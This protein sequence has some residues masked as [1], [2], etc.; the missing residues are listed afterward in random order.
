LP[1][2][3]SIEVHLGTYIKKYNNLEKIWDWAAKSGYL[4]VI[5]WLHENL[6]EGCTTHAMDVAAYKGH[7][8]IVKWLHE[9]RTEGCSSGAI[10]LAACNGHLDIIKFVHEKYPKAD[11]SEHAMN[12]AIRDGHFNVVKYIH[13]NKLFYIDNLAIMFAIECDHF[14]IFKWLC[15]NNIGNKLAMASHIDHAAMFGRLDVIKW[16]HK[17]VSIKC[18]TDDAM[19]NAVSSGRLEVVKWLHKNYPKLDYTKDAID[20]AAKNGYADVVQYLK[21]HCSELRIW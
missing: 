18:F 3:L 9:N 13:E 16:L 12:W 20:K 4:E 10:T 1:F 17:K 21:E 2:E 19:N 5:K 8:N 11:C 15:I 14:E 6:V 7:F